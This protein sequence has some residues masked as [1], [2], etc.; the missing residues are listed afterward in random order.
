MAEPLATDI[1]IG[2]DSGESSVNAEGS[3]QVTTISSLHCELKDG[4]VT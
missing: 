4:R 1:A 2:K 3:M